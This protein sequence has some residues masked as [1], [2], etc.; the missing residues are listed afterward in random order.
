MEN[1]SQCYLAAQITFLGSEPRAQATSWRGP[2]GRP[3]GRH[4]PL[5]DKSDRGGFVE[6]PSVWED[7]RGSH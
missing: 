6:D 7:A 4:D 5:W 1:I 3:F 2:Y